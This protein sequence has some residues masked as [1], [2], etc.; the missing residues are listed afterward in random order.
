MATTT[1]K[2]Q[3]TLEVLSSRQ[4]IID[5][6]EAQEVHLDA[7]EAMH[8]RFQEAWDEHHSKQK[9]HDIEELIAI[10]QAK[11][12]DLADLQGL[13]PS[14]KKPDSTPAEKINIRYVTAAGDIAEASISGRG[15]IADEEVSTFVTYCKDT[16]GIKR[17]D[18]ALEVMDID[19][20]KEAFKE[21]IEQVKAAA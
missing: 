7:F 14:K 10:M 18:L 20:F 15:R 19:S 13:K 17:A 1:E 4:N 16:K 21:Y 6:F 3:Y 9:Q 11:G 2:Q 8:T 12:I 5:F